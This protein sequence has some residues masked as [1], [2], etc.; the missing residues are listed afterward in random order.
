MKESK[1]SKEITQL[2]FLLVI[3]YFVMIFGAK[4][5]IQNFYV[6]FKISKLEEFYNE[7]IDT[8]TLEQLLEYA[9]EQ[10]FTSTIKPKKIIEKEALNSLLDP[11]IKFSDYTQYLNMFNSIAGESSGPEEPGTIIANF[12]GQSEPI[13][14]ADKDN[15]IT[16][17]LNSAI[18]NDIV[19]ITM[20][21]A[22]F[23]T[24]IFVVMIIS[25]SLFINRRVGKPLD[26]LSTYIDDIANLNVN[27]S[28]TFTHDDEI[29]K[30]GIALMNMEKDLNR[31]IVNRNELLRAIT[32]ELKTP[33]AH[34]VTL[35]YLHKSEVGEYADFDF[36][37]DQVQKIISE[38]NE[39]IQ[40]TLNSLS[41]TDK[42]K[43]EFNLKPFIE[44]KIH[45]FEVYLTGKSIDL[46][47]HQY[48]FEANPVPLNLVFNN[49]L[50]NA[51]KY[52]YSFLSVTN[53]EGTVT[54]A[55]DFKDNAGS[56][57]GKTIITRLGEFENFDIKA[58]EEDGIYTTVIKLNKFK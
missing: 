27:N 7:N 32:H 22:I 40:V 47:L 34:I 25:V 33:L 38:N 29:A 11:D 56:G 12:N 5:F 6:D 35:M 54:I 8:L 42:L 53:N 43:Q 4:I 48:T 13:H 50:L 23:T 15:L 55:N 19:L 30:I 24:L 49:L 36:V 46:D 41:E 20:A 57:V 51:S 10:G 3:I 1:L 16:L 2:N 28:L 14:F 37:N 31:E 52:S 26:K 21:I 45:T 44:N 18:A 39:L 17:S 9:D 58:Y